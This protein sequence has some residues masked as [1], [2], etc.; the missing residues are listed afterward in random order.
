MSKYFFI[1]LIALVSAF[2]Y[3]SNAQE[4]VGDDVTKID[5]LFLRYHFPV[6]DTLVY[7]VVSFDS[8]IVEFGTPLLKKRFEKIQLICD[9]VGK[10]GNFFIRQKFTDFFSYETSGNDKGIERKSSP[11]LG[12]EVWY[13]IDSLG[14]RYS[15]GYINDSTSAALNPG[16]A[17]QPNL[18]FPIQKD[19][20]YTRKSWLVSTNDALPENGLPPIRLNQ[21]SLFRAMKLLD[22]LGES[23]AR[24]EYVKT[25]QGSYKIA[26][27]SDSLK[28]TSVL[29]GYGVFDISESKRIPFHYIA[30]I[31]EKLTMTFSNNITKPA[32]HFIN[33][34]YTLESISTYIP[35]KTIAKPKAPAIPGKKK[36]N[37]R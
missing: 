5:T 33:S 32:T 18:I 16:G 2:S 6:K 29:N 12:R 9:S 10:N 37:K 14:T 28:V 13:E 4:T 11:W 26:T 8:I 19:T 34:F 24:I 20:T 21:S 31:E 36:K 15:S 27:E 7:R 3:Q 1:I 22:T 30:T 25:G 17:F 35:P 23:C